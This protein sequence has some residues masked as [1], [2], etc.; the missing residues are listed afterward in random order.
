LE[1]ELRSRDRICLWSEQFFHIADMRW[2]FLDYM[3]LRDRSGQRFSPY[4]YAILLVEDEA[5]VRLLMWHILNAAGFVVHLAT[6]GFDGLRKFSEV[7]RIDLLI[8][9]L[10]MPGMT[11]LQ[12]AARALENLPD[13]KVIYATGSQECFPETRADITC[14]TKPFTVEEL[15]TAVETALS[16][17]FRLNYS[18]P[19][20]GAIR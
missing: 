17:C 9:D 14:L 12:L 18:L 6:D 5:P 1:K 11:G 20:E 15:L 19:H 10:S 13:L 3:N 8:T 7:T 16:A 2:A 4:D